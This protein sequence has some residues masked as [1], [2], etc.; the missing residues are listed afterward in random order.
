MLKELVEELKEKRLTIDGYQS[1]IAETEAEL[2][3]LPEWGRLQKYKQMLEEVRQEERD[4]ENQIRQQAVEEYQRTGEKKPAAGIGIRVY[5]KL[6]YEPEQAR[7]WCYTNLREA[8]RLDKTAFEKYAKGVA[9]VKP[10]GFV[11]F[12]EE[13]SATIAKEL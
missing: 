6:K 13:P 9:D 5:K 10:I 1:L 11:E 2:E 7:A 12:Y 4:L 8:L 3:E